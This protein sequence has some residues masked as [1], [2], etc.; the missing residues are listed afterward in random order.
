MEVE[1]SGSKPSAAIATAAG[2][3]QLKRFDSL[4]KDQLRV[5]RK[6]LQ[7]VLEQCQRALQ[8]LDTTSDADVDDDDDA[9]NSSHGDIVDDQRRQRRGSTSS[10]ADCEADE[11]WNFVDRV[12]RVSI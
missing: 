4:H 7:A 1:V 9:D 6:T 8:S 2:A 10:R 5:K 12:V 3:A 11:V